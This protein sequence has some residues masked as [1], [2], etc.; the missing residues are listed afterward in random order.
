MASTPAGPWLLEL[1]QSIY[2]F[3]VQD[4]LLESNI[5]M[6]EQLGVIRKQIKGP[7]DIGRFPLV[8]Y[9]MLR[10]EIIIKLQV[11]ESDE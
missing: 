7:V 8:A 11:P 1:S 4:W 10:E 9:L 2:R 6:F 3:Q 5:L